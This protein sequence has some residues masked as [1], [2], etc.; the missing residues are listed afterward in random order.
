MVYIYIQNHIYIYN[1]SI[2]D[3]YKHIY[4]QIDRQTDR[5]IEIQ[6]QTDRQID[7]KIDRQVG[8]Q[9]ESMNS[10]FLCLYSYNVSMLHV[11]IYIQIIFMYVHR[12]ISILHIRKK[13]SYAY[14]YIYIYQIVWE[15]AW[16]LESFFWL[17]QPLF[18]S[19]SK[20][21][22]A[23]LPIYYMKTKTHPYILWLFESVCIIPI[24][25]YSMV[26]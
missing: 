3:D 12:N 5:K 20:S 25:N 21:E 18:P 2:Q 8:R 14:I 16:H 9:T 24:H 23:M 17:F 6:I 26:M 13:Y 10:S 7:R 22:P 19:V 1:T 15:S 11:H 4:R